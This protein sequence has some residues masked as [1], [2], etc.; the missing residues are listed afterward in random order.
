MTGQAGK[1]SVLSADRVLQPRGVSYHI[2]YEH[3]VDGSK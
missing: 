3:D 1:S 2:Y